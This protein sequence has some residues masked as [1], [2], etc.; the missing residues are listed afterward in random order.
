VDTL[1]KNLSNYPIYLTILFRI[2]IGVVFLWAS[3]DKIIDP[4]SFAKNISYYHI[5]PFGLENL[6]ALFLPWLELIIGS[7]LI[8]GIFIRANI[9]LSFILLVIFNIL[10]FQAIIRGFNIECG[11]GL[12]DGQTIGIEKLIENFGLLLICFLLFIRKNYIFSIFPKSN[13]L[14]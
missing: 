6:I 4:F 11:C 12:K 9:I 14:D 5:I 2:I 8:L 7:S 13:L 10:I 3:V 1:S